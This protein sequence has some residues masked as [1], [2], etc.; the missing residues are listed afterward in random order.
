[1]YCKAVLGAVHLLRNTGRRGVG[2]S[3]MLTH[4]DKGGVGGPERPEIVL[5]NK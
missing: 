3:Q 2:V 5:R 1:M 4:C